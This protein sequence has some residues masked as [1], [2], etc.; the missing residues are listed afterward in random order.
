VERVKIYDRGVEFKE[1][2]TFGEYTLTYRTGDI[3]SPH[4]PATEP[5]QTE[6]GHFLDCALTG[7]TPRTDGLSGLRVVQALEAIER[8]GQNGSRMERIRVPEAAEPVPL[9]A[10]HTNGR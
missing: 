5:L 3:V 10:P 1:P 9:R 8:S 7:A 2:T 4:I 6:I